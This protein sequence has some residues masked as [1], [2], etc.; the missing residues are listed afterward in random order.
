MGIVWLILKIIGITLL[1]ILGLILF[2]VL[3]ILITPF[4]YQVNASFHDKA[5]FAEVKFHFWLRAVVARVTFKDKKLLGILRILFIKKKLMEKDF[6]AP[7]SPVND[8]SHVLPD[9]SEQLLAD[10][11]NFAANMDAK[12]ESETLTENATTES[13]SEAE[14]ST[15]NKTEEGESNSE[16]PKTEEA[17]GETEGNETADVAEEAEIAEGVVEAES[18]GIAAKLEGLKEKGEHICKAVTEKKEMVDRYVEFATRDYTKR[19]AKYVAKKG[20]KILKS[21]RPRKCKG[22]ITFGLRDP[23]TMGMIC[24]Y[25]GMLYP[26]YYKAIDVQPLFGVDHT[27]IDGE[28]EIKGRII[29]MA[30]VARAVPILFKKDCRRVWKE[31][32]K[33]RKH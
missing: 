10:A 11:E 12:A 20:I 16:E 31:F 30:V 13:M 25:S 17:S 28:I 23:K 33:L 8:D 26:V 18:S 32:K 19:A 29:L 3:V 5:P 4:R 7:K 14:T 6:G 21:I 27:V 22:E 1:V 15:E 24:G 2:L 9:Q